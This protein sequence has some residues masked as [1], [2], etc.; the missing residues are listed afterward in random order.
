MLIKGKKATLIDKGAKLNKEIKSRSE[1]L[2]EIKSKLKKLK[3]ATYT[4]EN[5]SSVTIASFAAFHEI[6]PVKAEKA[7]KKKKLGKN[8]MKCI[9]VLIGPLSSFLSDEELS[10]IRKEKEPTIRISFKS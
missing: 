8:F 2:D 9:K 1:A 3:P 10:A 4:T 6:D 5:G 7:L